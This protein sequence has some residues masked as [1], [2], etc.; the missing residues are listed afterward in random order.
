MS[1]DGNYAGVNYQASVIAYVFVHALTD[2]KLRW[3]PL[4]DDTPSAIAG[5]VHGPGDDARVEFRAG[6][7]PIE[8]QAKFGLKPQKC[9]EAFQTIRDASTPSDDTLVWLVV[10]PTSSP[11]VRNELSRDLDRLRT[12]RTDSLRQLTQGILS[13]LGSRA[14]DVMRRTHILT[15]DLGR[16]SN[17]STSRALEILAESLDDE[18][19]AAAAWAV[20][21]KDAAL[22]C[23]EKT[24][25]TKQALIDVLAGVKIGVRP[26]RRTRKWHDDLRHTKKLLEDEE[27]A[28]AFS[29]LRQIESDF[30]ST[31]IQ[32]GQVL[33]KIS[34]HRSS[35]LLK[36]QRWQEAINSAE[37]ALDHDP[38]GIHALVNLALAQELSGDI[39]SAVA[40]AIRATTTHAQSPSAWLIRLRLPVEAG[41]P[42]IEVPPEV[43]ST[44]EFRFGLVGNHLF[45]GEAAPARDVIASLIRDGDRSPRA[46]LLRAVTLFADI[47]NVTDGERLD[48]AREVERL[49]TEVLDS[50]ASLS[51][52]QT[53]EA[54]ISRS[55]AR[56]ILGN[57]SGAQD[58]SERAHSIR[59]DD[60]RA[61]FMAASTRVLAGDEDGALDILSGP[62]VENNPFLRAQRASLRAAK[63]Q[64]EGAQKDLEAALRS[65]PTAAEPDELRSAAAEA[66]LR[67]GDVDLA[68]KLTAE[69]ALSE[70][71]HSVTHLVTL[72]RIAALE[73][74]LGEAENRYREAIEAFPFTRTELLVELGSSLLAAKKP[75]AAA[76]AL[77]EAGALDE[78]AERMLVRALVLSDQLLAANQ[79]LEV[80]A[81]KG[82][83]PD[84]AVGIAAQIALRRN[85]PEAAAAHLEDLFVRGMTTAGGHLKLAEILVGL[86]RRDRARVHCD[87]L[88]SDPDLLPHER[89]FLAH[90]QSKLGNF[91]VAIQQALKAFRDQPDDAEMNRAFVS[92]VVGTKSKPVEVGFVGPDTH[93]FLVG[94]G[95]EILEYVLFADS[96]A[97][98]LTN[99]ISL[100]EAHKI[101]LVG[102]RVGDLFAR[103]QGA[104]FESRFRVE[105]IQSAVKYLVNDIMA[106]YGRRFPSEEFF[107]TTFS[108]NKD[109]SGVSEF[110][111]L[112]SSTHERKRYQDQIFKLYLEHCLPLAVVSKLTGGTVPDVITHV[113]RPQSDLPLYVEF[114]DEGR[115]ASR[116]AAR[117][118]L[119]TILSRSALHTAQRFE[120][121]SLLADGRR[122][123]A[124]I[125]LRAEIDAEVEEAEDRIKSGWAVVAPSE[126]GFLF[127]QTDAGDPSLVRERDSIVGLRDWVVANVT[128]VPRPL[129]V[130]SDPRTKDHE[131]IRTNL[132]ASSNDALELSMFVP[133]VLHA[134]DLG[135][136]KLASGLGLSSFS[137]VSLIQIWAEGGALS[138]RERDQR[139]VDLAEVHYYQIE[140]SPEVLIEALAPGRPQQ[141]SREVFSLLAAAPLEVQSSAAMLVR[142]VKLVAMQN[143]K[144]TTAERVIR[145]GL[146]AMAE[147]FQAV[148]IAHALRRAADIDLAL[149]PRERQIV[150]NAANNLLKTRLIH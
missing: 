73:G 140:V 51:T 86:N 60:A 108:F 25:R 88:A 72:A 119:P 118:Q 121:L 105:R 131:E 52:S 62:V 27:P 132:G 114:H 6:T 69:M 14:D 95:S 139:L 127:H 147:R 74:D 135:L 83:M 106:S 79:A 124:P 4:A 134:D 29:L 130:F 1:G 32:D 128:F 92:L 85:D 68:K 82:P 142:A 146:E 93:V 94:D 90:L 78:I 18:S 61:L 70:Q 138:A 26:P 17:A 129:E 67:I 24:R 63:G 48:R 40:T 30:L 148:P 7:A 50:D 36:M 109:S 133:G 84:W 9:I 3:L 145:E 77:R 81:N 8:I 31:G 45:S 20:F 97:S 101:G 143:V 80:V 44:S 37:R 103:N 16:L 91:S 122:C 87:A 125:S 34:Q 110:Q 120:F 15:L 65:I 58:D 21:E 13:A 113:S 116:T 5:E 2:T 59:P 144:T 100:E 47:E 115:V 56:R 39:Q 28:L 33:Y 117:S 137:T 42:P 76:Q 150:V 71:V 12:G 104:F 49:C 98:R 149:L 11:A 111:P 126:R 43:A 96:A 55:H 57:R 41:Q 22:M 64:L 46:L 102:L 136:R 54:L 123:L 66:A 141:A 89:M 35:A 99:E 38:H 112:I 10:D 19:Q 53:Q 107:V 75:A 23:A